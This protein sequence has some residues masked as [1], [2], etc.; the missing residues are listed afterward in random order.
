MIF[1]LL[2]PLAGKKPVLQRILV[3]FGSTGPG[4]TTMHPATFLPLTAGERQADSFRIFAQQRRLR[5]IGTAL[6]W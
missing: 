2:E 5:A 1:L 3:A 4:G 6:R